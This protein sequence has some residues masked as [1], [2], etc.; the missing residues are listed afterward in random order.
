[1]VHR[2]EDFELD[3]AVGALT[4]NGAL[5][6]LQPRPLALL[7]FLVSNRGRVVSKEEMIR[8]V[9]HGNVVS[10]DAIATAVRDIRRALKSQNGRSDLLRT[11]YA[12]GLEFVGKP[13]EAITQT[14]QSIVVAKTD[15]STLAVLPFKIL[16]SD[17]EIGLIAQG[18][19]EDMIV[20][21]TRRGD[22]R[23][24]PP[25][26]VSALTD[27]GLSPKA[28]GAGL[29][30]DYMLDGSVR[31]IGDGIRITAQ[32][33][34]AETGDFVW[35]DMFELPTE[36]MPV[37]DDG[38]SETI[39]RSAVKKLAEFELQSALGKGFHWQRAIRPSPWPFWG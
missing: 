3:A 17:P 25:L 14:R 31:A 37:D 20:Q 24:A 35:A 21:F 30:A 28:M 7:S 5:I 8:E 4:R 22:V 32:L 16:S 19:V 1:M 33:L 39:V 34:R 36:R 23:V 15:P 6:S 18:L 38:I 27:N 2:F 26:A 9:W 13:M 11:H 29:G 10:D 12:R